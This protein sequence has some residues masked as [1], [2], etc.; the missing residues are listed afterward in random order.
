VTTTPTLPPATIPAGDILIG[1]NN[2]D[3]VIKGGFGE[4]INLTLMMKY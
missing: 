3:K 1:K 4:F 2:N